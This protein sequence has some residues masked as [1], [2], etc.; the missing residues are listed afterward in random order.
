[1]NDDR[2][3]RSIDVDEQLCLYS[4]VM[5]EVRARLLDCRKRIAILRKLEPDEVQD[6]HYF[7]YE[8]CCLHLRMICEGIAIGALIAHHHLK[9]DSKVLD[10]W[11][12]ANALT[13][14]ETINDRCFPR[15]MRIKAGPVYRIEILLDHL[16]FDEMKRIYGQLGGILHRGKIKKVIANPRRRYDMGK[17]VEWHNALA[18]LLQKHVVV[19]RETNQFFVADLFGGK[20]GGV[21]VTLMTGLPCGGS[22][23]LSE[24]QS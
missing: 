7:E 1:M 11:H 12:A 19:I 21:V 2:S 14:L 4:N 15:A 20:S 22:D 16:K 6:D 3:A 23:A 5:T 13:L 9:I 10:E 18:K 8:L 17:L 24:A